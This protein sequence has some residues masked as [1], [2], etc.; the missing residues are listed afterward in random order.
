[1]AMKPQTKKKLKT[2]AFWSGIVSALILFAQNVAALFGM[3]IPQDM[4]ANLLAAA[5]SLLA[6]LAMSGVLVNPDQVD[7]FQTL[8]HKIRKK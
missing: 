6:L 3:E 7:S 8:N 2:T 4:V 1:M 5:N